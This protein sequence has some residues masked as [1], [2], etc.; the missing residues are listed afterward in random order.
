MSQLESPLLVDV[1]A[2]MIKHTSNNLFQPFNVDKVETALIVPQ[3]LLKTPPIKPITLKITLKITQP[4]SAK[5]HK[6]LLDLLSHYPQLLMDLSF[7]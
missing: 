7:Y 2:Q 6:P 4:L 5:P 3:I 1:I